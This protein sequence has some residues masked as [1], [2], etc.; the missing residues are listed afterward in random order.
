MALGSALVD[1][2]RTVSNE[3]LPRRVEGRT[4]RASVR[5]EWF[6]ARLEPVGGPEGTDPAGGRRRVVAGTTL[7]YGPRDAAGLSVVVT[8]E[9]L[10][11][12]DSR[13][14]GRATWRVTS[15]PTPLRRKRTVI[16]F[17]VPVQLVTAR[18]MDRP[19]APATISGRSLRTPF[20]VEEAA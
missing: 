15:D 13:E 19:P 17:Q 5:G 14:L 2:A 3:P 7:L 11:E 18:Q 16:G 1:R 10:L 6:R 4:Q 12:I 9:D 8:T 20:V